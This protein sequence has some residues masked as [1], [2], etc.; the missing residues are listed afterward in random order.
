V[1]R[2][3][4]VNQTQVQDLA[5]LLGQFRGGELLLQCLLQPEGLA[6]WEEPHQAH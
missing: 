4:Q 1:D 3:H 2:H 5:L 6:V